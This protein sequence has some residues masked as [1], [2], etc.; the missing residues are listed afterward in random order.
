MKTIEY[1]V[2]EAL[3]QSEF[4]YKKRKKV[5]FIVNYFES[6]NLPNFCKDGPT[7]SNF[8]QQLLLV[9]FHKILRNHDNGSF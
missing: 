6:F 4:Y 3:I 1:I 8:S 2:L 9:E 5:G 7:N